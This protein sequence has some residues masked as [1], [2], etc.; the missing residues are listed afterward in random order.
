[1]LI[2]SGLSKSFGPR[3]LFQ[4]AAFQVQRGD[5]IGLVGANGVG[6]TTLFSLILGE[7]EPDSGQVEL[8]RDVTLGYL[9]QESAP[10]GEE[11]VL[12][13][14]AGISRELVEVYAEMR[15]FPDPSEER[16]QAAEARWAELNAFS[17]EARARK[18]L[19]GLAFRNEDHDRLAST[20][21]GGWVMRAHLARLLVQEP[22]LLMLD[23]PTNHL[24][25]ESLGWFQNHLLQYPGSILVISHDR[26]FLNAICGYV[27]EIEH[28][29]I[30][31]YTGN[32]DEFL[33]Q[34]KARREQQWAAY[35]NQQREI[36]H[37]Q[38]FVDR[39]RYKASKAS[40][41]Q[42]RLKMIERME[43]IEPPDESA[44]KLQ[45]RFPP[46]P[47]GGH[48]VIELKA[49]RQAYGELVVY[50]DLNLTLERGERIV[51][52]GP[53]GA[54]KSTL[55]KI[56]GGVVPI[57]GGEVVRGMGLKVGY[58]SQ[59][60]TEGL[61][62]DRSV[63]DE[64]SRCVLDTTEQELRAL[65]GAFLFSGDDIHKRVSVL[66][67]GE[68]SRLA[69]VKMLLQPP[70]LLL[71]DEPTTHLDLGSID[72]LIQALEGYP[73]T[74]VIVSHDVHFIRKTAR[75]VIHIDRGRLT[76]YA[77]DYDYYLEKSA[78]TSARQGLVAGWSDRRPEAPQSEPAGKGMNGGSAKDRRREAARQR[79]LQ[80]QQEREVER[81][82]AELMRWE[83]RQQQLLA[84]IEGVSG[85]GDGARLEAL[86]RELTDVVEKIAKASTAWEAAVEA[87]DG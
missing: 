77:G 4:D 47:R 63:W 76:P 21:S 50:E 52:V 78:A 48:K 46:P 8:Q 84:E 81:C 42:S 67:G 59:Q 11:T 3:T 75:K 40:Q 19:A 12:H 72:A 18:V 31:R 65:L 53:N 30:H 23:E 24:D 86:N 14:A 37:L 70:N 69:L 45:F 2:I 73:G 64:A 68:K 7:T 16:H 9:P 26:E 10:V 43:K 66:S 17:V 49:V 51:L 22:D 36:A 32:Y 62:M 83:T 13:L 20:L 71:L 80:R 54:G 44:S 28:K 25:L 87:V 33:I 38:S 34:K 39:F 1:M 56:L 60:R 15:R 79:E 74:L 5:R 55:L 41:A 29:G 27:V 58:F 6:K 82:E 61:Q 35:N 57:Q 85:K